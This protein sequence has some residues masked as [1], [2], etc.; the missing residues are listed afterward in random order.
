MHDLEQR[1]LDSFTLVNPLDC[2]I[3]NDKRCMHGVTAVEQMDP[4]KPAY[5]DVLVVTFRNIAN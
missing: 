3:V 1:R 2:A 4:E 5:R